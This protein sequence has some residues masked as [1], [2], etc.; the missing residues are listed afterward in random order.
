MQPNS[1]PYILSLT[2]LFATSGT[3]LY[4]YVAAKVR[5]AGDTVGRTGTLGTML[6]LAARYTALAKDR[7]WPRW[8]VSAMW[9]SAV[10]F[11]VLATIEAFKC[12]NR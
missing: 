12:F 8:P 2:I 5:S 7:G 11:M 4:Y 9:L 10:V 6:A 3:V 1:C